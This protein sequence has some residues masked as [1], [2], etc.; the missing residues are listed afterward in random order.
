MEPE[1]PPTPT[2]PA[3]APTPSPV[4][5]TT[6]LVPPSGKPLSAILNWKVLLAAAVVIVVLFVLKGRRIDAHPP[7][8]SAAVT[9]AVAKVTRE[10]LFNEVPIP[11]EF[12][13]YVEVELHAKVSGYVDKMNVDFGDK[14]KSGQLLA[15]LEVPELRDQIHNA[16]AIQQRDE[17]DYTNAHLIYGRLRSVN[18]EHPNLVAQQDLDTARAKDGAAC[19]AMAAAKADAERYQTLMNY[20]RIT[21]PFDGVITKRYVDPGALIQAGTASETQSLPVVRVSDN[22]HLRLDFPVS[23]DY[24]RDIRLGDPVDV[25]VDSLGGKK[26]TGTIKRFTNKVNNDT[27]TMIVELEVEN[28][29]LEI[30]P[31]MYAAVNLRVQRRPQVLAVPIEVI[32]STHDPTVYVVNGDSKIEVRSITLGLETPEKYE[33]ASGLQE[34]DLVMVGNR[35][36]VHPGQ[37]VEPLVI[38]NSVVP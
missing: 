15:T 23:V 27:R 4:S 22:Y 9:V 13:P 11:A 36:V 8:D 30:V 34:G 20:T 31:G 19:A 6:P 2:T 1:K 18:Q 21:A 14:V 12:R 16:L 5:E 37:I 17:A 35:S 38:T 32:G 7:T 10:D 29:S 25:R 3:P 28:P 33:V 26:F 24:V